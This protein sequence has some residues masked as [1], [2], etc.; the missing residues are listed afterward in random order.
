MSLICKNAFY[1]NVAEKTSFL[2]LMQLR[3]GQF[4]LAGEVPGNVL[5]F[6]GLEKV[7]LPAG[8]RLVLEEHLHGGLGGFAPLVGSGSQLHFVPEIY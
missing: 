1:V 7:F 8:A 2:L 4:D 5:F 6:D 3:C